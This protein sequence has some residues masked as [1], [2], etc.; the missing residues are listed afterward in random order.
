[1][2]AS[3]GAQSRTVTFAEIIDLSTGIEHQAAHEPWKPS[4]R[5]IR[6]EIE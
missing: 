4:I 2:N 6:H 3:T 5:R 1:M